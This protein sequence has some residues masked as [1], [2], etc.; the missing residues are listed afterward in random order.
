[1]RPDLIPQLYGDGTLM[2]PNST[3]PTQ[4]L[5]VTAQQYRMLGQWAQ[6]DFDND[7]RGRFET[8]SP[9]PSGVEGLDELPLEQRPLALD[10]AA[11]DSCLGGAFH[12]GIE[13]PWIARVPSVWAEPFRLKLRSLTPDTANWGT[14]LTAATALSANGPLNGCTPGDVTRW[15]GIPWHADGASCRSG[16]QRSISPVLPAFWP[17]RVPNHVLSEADYRIVMD[18]TRPLAERKAAFARRRDWERFIARPTRPPTLALMVE[19]WFRQGIVTAR[20]GPGDAQFPAV[21]QVESQ[22]GY[23]REP[24]ITYESWYWVP[25]G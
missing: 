2:P 12:P 10:R 21:I 3:I 20:P 25:Q 7:R 6:G 16:Y 14:E 8:Q 18:R 13:F 17:A 23:E 9:V 19:E 1:V 5:S 22:I 15:L 24:S 11:L 4:W